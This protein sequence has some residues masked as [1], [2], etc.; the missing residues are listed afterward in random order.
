MILTPEEREALADRIRHLSTVQRVNDP[1]IFATMLRKG[2]TMKR[3]TPEQLPPAPITPS[4]HLLTET[5]QPHCPVEPSIVESVVRQT[6]GHMSRRAIPN[7]VSYLGDMYDDAIW[8][9]N[10]AEQSLRDRWLQNGTPLPF[11]FFWGFTTTHTSIGP[12]NTA[13]ESQVRTFN[14]NVY[15]ITIHPEV[16]RFTIRWTAEFE[17]L[18]GGA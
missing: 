8:L 6:F 10:H 4:H 17:T 14:D 9:R 11:S 18:K 15:R 12:D 5:R 13:A 1:G 3:P 7:M 2:D 16:D